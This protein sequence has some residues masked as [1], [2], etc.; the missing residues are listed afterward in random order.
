MAT[1]T[2]L[3]SFLSADFASGYNLSPINNQ[4]SELL[5][6]QIALSEGPIYRIN[7]NGPQDIEINDKYIDDLIDFNTGL[8]KPGLLETQYVTGTVIQQPMS[9]FFPEIT[10]QVR[11][12]SPI[13]LKSGISL[14]PSIL[15]PPKTSVLFYPTN[16]YSTPE[17]I[18]SIRF[19]FNI[20]GLKS[21]NDSGSYPEQIRLLLIIH[22]YSESSNIDNYINIAE[23]TIDALVE[24]DLAVEYEMLIPETKKSSSGYKVSAIKLN[25]DVSTING[26]IAEIEFLGFDEIT[27]ISL[28]YPTTAVAGYILR[29]SEFRTDESVVITSAVKGLLVDVPSNYNQPI[30]ENGEV[31]WREIEVP[32]SGVMSA[33]TC[34][35]RLQST[36]QIVQTSSSINIYKGIWDG[37]FKKDWTQNPAWIIRDLILRTGLPEN[38]IDNYNFYVA[39]QYFDA[40]NSLTGNFV[41]VPGFADGT[42]RY[43]SR[44]YLPEI[45]NILLGLPDGTEVL[46]RRFTCD[47]TITDYTQ[48]ADIIDGI[49]SACRSIVTT[50]AGKFVIITEKE[51]LLSQ[52]FFN[53]TNIE[54]SSFSM[55]G[56]TESDIITGIEVSYIDFLDHYKKKTVLL[57]DSDA[58]YE[59]ENKKSIDAV[60]CTKKSQALR[61][62]KYA[63]ESN[64]RTRRKIQFNSYVNSSDLSVGSIISVSQSGNNL[65]YGFGGLIAQDAVYGSTTLTL[66]QVTHPLLSASS[67]LDTSQ[68]NKV[69]L[70]IFKN[71]SSTV[72]YY[73]VQRA[74]ISVVVN[75]D[76][77][78]TITLTI[79]QKYN[80][81]TGV[82][83]S[84]TGFT[85]T[86]IKFNDIWSMGRGT[87]SNQDKAG[88]LFRIDS[89]QVDSTGKTS[90]AA[91]E[92]DESISQYSDEA[93]LHI[94]GFTVSSQNFNTPPIPILNLG[95]SPYKTEEGIVA[96]SII[97][98]V[99]T[100]SSNYYV[101]LSTKLQIA[102][103][104]QFFTITDK[105]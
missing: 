62:A 31:D 34:G 59:F 19:K 65:S 103:I 56:I 96:H 73:A 11:F 76:N 50:R 61:V 9:R 75:T 42:Y 82:W 48:V 5:Y 17:Q 43:K 38:C 81:D 57:N 23:F 63:L 95:S 93:V 2:A 3:G 70:K 97:V 83:S 69:I 25:E 7:P 79:L 77:T 26:Y 94:P 39:A 13:V 60:G 67:F 54:Q 27:K 44:N 32:S 18:D 47:I 72:E 55:V 21:Q 92:Y 101:P 68:G 16:S 15:P 71:E 51:G 29:S 6:T 28:A 46:E 12:S 8:A 40:V 41:G 80:I 10:E 89:I 84:F 20:T 86:S 1:T 66:T 105:F 33:T 37:T 87:I 49:A 104:P 99:N 24:T 88:K 98:N 58:V 52:N 90:I 30:L 91:S 64:N 100:D 35:Y 85:D 14:D 78:A 74:T 36:S 4:S 45:E 22:P 102:Q 53:E